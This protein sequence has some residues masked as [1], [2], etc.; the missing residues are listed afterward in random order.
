L[1]HIPGAA[2]HHGAQ[3]QVR[4][5]YLDN[6]R[7]KRNVSD[8]DRVGEISQQEVEEMLAETAVS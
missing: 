4:A 5:D 2:R 8:Y 3:A 6:C 1:G 7:S